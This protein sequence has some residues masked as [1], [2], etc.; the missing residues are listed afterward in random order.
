[1]VIRPP[2]HIPAMSD[3]KSKVRSKSLSVVGVNAA[4]ADPRNRSLSENT[5]PGWAELE[6]LA[7]T[8]RENQ[9]ILL[10]IFVSAVIAISY[11]LGNFDFSFLW[12]FIL[13]IITFLIWWSKVIAL[14][15]DHI[16]YQEVILHR[17]R[18]LR[19]SETTEWLNFIINRW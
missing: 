19:H 12:V 13:I 16:R 15:E 14:T 5:H 17:K 7:K 9:Q 8:G 3:Q 11:T 1:M 18:A 10:Y 2:H 4:K 6:K